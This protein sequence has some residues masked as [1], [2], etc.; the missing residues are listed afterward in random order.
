VL[1][2][3]SPARCVPIVTGLSPHLQDRGQPKSAKREAHL[4]GILEST[5]A[6]SCLQLGKPSG[7]WG[8]GGGVTGKEAC[9][10]N[11]HEGRH[12]L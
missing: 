6:E 8:H 4:L 1:K 7:A 9:K 3:H 12:R 5:L 2:R 11:R 10:Q